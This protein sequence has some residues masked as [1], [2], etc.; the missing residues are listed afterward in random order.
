MNTTRKS[1]LNSILLIMFLTV[2]VFSN[3]QKIVDGTIATE[4]GEPFKNVLVSISGTFNGNV[5][6]DENG[7]YQFSIPEGGDYI[8]TPCHNLNPL[9][10]VSTYDVVS[11]RRHIDG[12]EQ[13]DSPYKIIAAD[14]D[15]NEI[16]NNTDTFLIRQ[17]TISNILAFPDNNSWRFIPQNFIFQ[18]P[19]NPFSTVFPENGII[20][21]LENDTTIN[22]I[23]VK[24][25]D[26]NTTAL[27]TS[28]SADSVD[29]VH[30]CFQDIPNN[31]LNFNHQL[32]LNIYPNPFK[33][34]FNIN[35]GKNFRQTIIEIYSNTGNLIKQKVYY[36]TDFITLDLNNKSSGI[37]FV[38]IINNEK[39]KWVSIIKSK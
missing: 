5:L 22:F 21:N 1:Y 20:N 28:F 37:Y 29:I 33:N 31:N 12:V 34:R 9:N 36:N 4:I 2:S 11:V 23:S 24:I 17:L 32:D 39:S 38:K 26:V 30:S 35:L 25:G 16:I 19:E 6:T 14:V 18:N 13:L 8:V 27:P 7:Y 3:A 15:H 10:G